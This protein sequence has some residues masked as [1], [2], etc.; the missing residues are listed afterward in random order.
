MSLPPAPQDISEHPQAGSV[1]APTDKVEQAA[2][3]DRKIKLYGVVQAL[4]QGRMP[5][6]A[7]ILKTLSYLEHADTV[8]LA[9]LSPEGKTLIRDFRSMISTARLIVSQKN[10]DELFQNFVW[11]TREID[12][13]SAKPASGEAADVDRGKL[14]EDSRTAV[15]H[16]RTLLSLILTNSE[17]R[18]LLSD[19]SLIGRD[20]LAR[21][22]T[23]AAEA[24]RP[25]DEEMSHV[26]EPAPEGQFVSKGGQTN[27]TGEIG[28]QIP[29]TDDADGTTV[30]TSQGEE[31]TADKVLGEGKQAE[32]TTKTGEEAAEHTIQKTKE[33]QDGAA[34]VAS[35]HS[36][37]PE[38]AEEKKRDFKDR[39][40]GM[41]AERSPRGQKTHAREQIQKGE[42]F[43]MDEY[44]PAGRRDQFIY[45]GKKV[46]VE[47]QKHDDYQDAIKWLLSV[48]EEYAEFGHGTSEKGKESASNVINDP[49]LRQAVSELRQLLERFADA[50]TM[51]LIFESIDALNDDAR[52]DEEFRAWFKRLN[53]FIRKFLLEAGYVLQDECS[54]EGK[55]IRE[56]GRKFWDQ[57]YR[58]HFDNVFNSIGDWFSAMSDDPLNN[59]FREDWVH[60]TRDLLFDSEGSLKFKSRLWSDIRSVIVP[61][62]VD[63]VGYFPIP[64]IEYSDDALDL[65]LENLTLQGR[66]LFPNIVT[67][68][69][70]NYLKF[71]PY[72]SISDEDRHEFTFTF[73]QIQADMRDVAF[74]FRKKT[75][76]PKVVDSGMADV[77]IG[78]TGLT[79]VVQLV[80]AGKDRSSVFKVKD[81]H[82]KVGSLK[83]SIRESKHDL[84]YKTMKPIATGLVKRQIKKAIAGAIRTGMEYV[85]GQLVSVRDHMEETKSKDEMHHTQVLHELFKRPK[86][87]HSIRSSESKSQFKLVSS[88]RSSIIDTGHPSGWVSR[89]SESEEKASTGK[90]WRSEACVTH[91]LL[92]DER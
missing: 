77:I 55:D 19:F 75:G 62:L 28:V 33:S 25:G 50:K 4:R 24:L 13:E 11:H 57:K 68:V 69:A 39:F 12:L 76:F 38:E 61:T 48:A 18:K 31:S 74:F 36:A 66:N 35:E 53:A 26:D 67:L 8:D 20:L 71:S 49:T 15:R 9:K 64:R 81:V 46:I 87:E 90:D 30:E 84:L 63:K 27:G 78:G 47:C 42:H 59:R 3:V 52:R 2:D 83:F 17:V 43:L 51:H 45:R 56:S 54:R 37:E 91:P 70:H 72:S 82:V 80:S 60:L 1:A 89:I 6:N 7:Q 22:A 21:G 44:F 88:K 79:A 34:G 40:K 73:A 65:V 29:R 86:E 14:R 41:F 92:L 58:T 32:A 5:D 85:D 16:L 10:A 23:K